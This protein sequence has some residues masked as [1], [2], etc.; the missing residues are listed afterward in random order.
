MTNVAAGPSAAL[1]EAVRAFDA[2][3]GGFDKRFGSWASVAAQRR[4]VRRELLRTFP[5]DALLLELGGGTGEDALFLARHG[6]RVVVTD[7]APAMVRR[8]RDKARAAGYD[9]R[10]AA[11]QVT[12]EDLDRFA[13]TRAARGEPPFDGAYSNFAALNCALDLS[14]VARALAALLAP[15]AHAVL[16]MF[17]PFTLAEVL[18]ELARGRPRNAF[19]RLARGAVPACIGGHQFIVRY[20]GRRTVAHQFAPHFRLLRTRGIGAFVPPSAAEPMISRFPRV[21]A[22]L[23]GV[24]RLIAGPLAWLSDHMLLDFER[25]DAARPEVTVP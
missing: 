15:H 1:P 19:R 25:V 2:M 14:P 3:A 11:E 7:G 10:I 6:R 12:L 5:P 18:I 21:L 4:A 16:V 9:D 17:G 22:V 13:S 23:E 24:D 20:P 8:T